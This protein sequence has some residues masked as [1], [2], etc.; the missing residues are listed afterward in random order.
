MAKGT[1]KRRGRSWVLRWDKPRSPDGKRQQGFKSIR[2]TKKEAEAELHR[3]MSEQDRGMI[4][5]AA[6]STTAEWLSHW[7]DN[8]VV[9]NVQPTTL[10]S[11]RSYVKTHLIPSIGHIKVRNLRPE[12]IEKMLTD[13]V[14]KGRTANTARHAFVAL[15]KAL[16][17]AEKRGVVASNPCRLV[18]AP[19]V[20]D[21]K[22]DPPSME[23]VESIIGHVNDPQHVNLFRL[24]AATGLRRGEAVSLRWNDVDLTGPVVSVTQAA[25]RLN[26]G[27][28]MVSSSPKT[29]SGRRGVSIDDGSVI[30]LRRH[31]ADQQ[32]R[33]LSGG[34]AVRDE[35]WVFPDP[36]GRMNDP[37]RL[38]RAWRQAAK[39]AGFPKVRLQDVRHHH[40][41]FLI[42][43][44]VHA[45]V[46]QE[47]LGHSTPSF[48]LSRY[49]HLTGGM[50]EQAASVY[51]DARSAMSE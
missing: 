26:D 10:Q 5:Q 36:Q 9:R 8:I 28:L 48:T 40:A 51:G 31:F 16:G 15:Q 30:M 50:Q 44:D 32:K 22:V 7:L 18:D 29:S 38:T 25:Q 23:E 33:V 14:E 2:G 46:V 1:V 4:Y 35:G 21:F 34:G 39:A 45:K 11:Y 17:D 47:R 3:L 43:H 27:T 42:A 13:I 49:V 19:R 24:M 6:K 20:H 37:D 41:S 12:Q